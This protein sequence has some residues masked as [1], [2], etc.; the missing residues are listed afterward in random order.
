MMLFALRPC[1]LKSL[2]W[3]RL[4]TTWTRRGV[5]LAVAVAAFGVVAAVQ[6]WG[7]LKLQPSESQL[8]LQLMAVIYSALIIFLALGHLLARGGRA[9]ALDDASWPIP[10]RSI[11]ALVLSWVANLGMLALFLNG[12]L[13]T[14]RGHLAPT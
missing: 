8:S 10:T 14:L 9:R 7:P 3:H 6:S 5:V 12:V 11:P 4:S 13:L 1:V 2:A